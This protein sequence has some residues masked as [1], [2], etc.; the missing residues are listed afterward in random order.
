MKTDQMRRAKVVDIFTA[1]CTGRSA[2]PLHFGRNTV[3]GRG[4][5]R[6]IYSGSKAKLQMCPGWLLLAWGSG[7]GAN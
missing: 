2:S 4:M 6:G 7:R 1:C 3:A 5:G